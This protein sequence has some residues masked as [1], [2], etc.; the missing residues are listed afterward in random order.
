ML[1]QQDTQRCFPGHKVVGT[2]ARM[3][4]LGKFLSAAVLALLAMALSAAQAA[5]IIG[6][7]FGISSAAETRVVIDASGPVTHEVTVDAS[8]QITVSVP[9]ASA[10]PLVGAPGDG[11]VARYAIETSGAGTTI[12]L[13][14]ARRTAVAKDFAIPA[15]KAGEVYR[16]VVDLKDGPAHEKA[17]ERPSE[18]AEVPP[19]PYEDLTKMLEAVV[20]PTPAAAETPGPPAA[21]VPKALPVIVIDAGHGGVDPGA[22][23]AGGKLEKSFTLAAAKRLSEIL[24]TRGRYEIVMTRAD[25]RRLSLDDRA[26]IAREAGGRTVRKIFI[27]LHADAHPDSAV[28]GGS[29]YTLSEDGSARSKNEARSNGDYHSVYGNE[30]ELEDL[31]PSI[32]KALY[33][34]AQD[35]TLDNSG[36]F[37][38]ILLR[39]LKGATTMLGK[40]RRSADLRVLLSPDVPAVL[41]EL[42]YISNEKDAANLASPAWRTRAMTAVADAIDEYFAE[43]PES[44]GAAGAPSGR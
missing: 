23:S 21:P 44:A 14:P 35:Y 11:H 39:R 26:K 5:E 12:I 7:R 16:I 27:S 6:V 8:G 2:V 24:Q 20:A 1:V 37:A 9:K 4:S 3:R 17:P 32:S 25:D 34:K 10:K 30:T 15:K 36:R 43:L 18:I 33:D 31:D 40:S 42:A 41:F 22:S 38:A 19:A 29:V 13:S 28:R